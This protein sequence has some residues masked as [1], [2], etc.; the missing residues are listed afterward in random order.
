[1]VIIFKSSLEPFSTVSSTFPKIFLAFNLEIDLAR[2]VLLNGS[3]SSIINSD[4]I[5]SSL[6]IL[7]PFISIL[8]TNT[9][10]PSKILNVISTELVDNFSDT[11]CSTN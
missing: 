8:S 5:T 9:F 10:S 2:L 4:L 7:L 1:M 6:V 11:E 3:P